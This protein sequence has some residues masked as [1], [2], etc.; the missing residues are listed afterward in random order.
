M[1]VCE[2]VFLPQTTRCYWIL[3]SFNRQEVMSACSTTTTAT[4]VM[5]MMRCPALSVDLVHAGDNSND[6]CV[7]NPAS[8]LA[9][10]PLLKWWLQTPPLSVK[11]NIQNSRTTAFLFLS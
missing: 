4:A 3:T 10:I 5:M 1:C 11:N 9:S 7:K 8:S 2:R 6:V